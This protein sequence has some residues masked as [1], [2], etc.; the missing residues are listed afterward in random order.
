[1]KSKTFWLKLFHLNSFKASNIIIICNKVDTKEKYHTI[2]SDFGVRWLRA[3]CRN[4]RE[5]S[6]GR[7]GCRVGLSP[8]IIFPFFVCFTMILY[9]LKNNYHCWLVTNNVGDNLLSLAVITMV[10]TNDIAPP[11]ARTS[12]NAVM[13]KR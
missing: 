10:I 11:R 5:I 7:E 9:F 1:M 4:T 8:K 2:T 12:G 3:C 6:C 13:N